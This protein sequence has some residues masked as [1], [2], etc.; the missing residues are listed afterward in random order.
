MLPHCYPFLLVDRLPVDRDA[1]SGSGLP[2]RWTA[3]GALDRGAG[4]APS[5]LA[6]EMMAQAG[7]VLL[8][9]AADGRDGSQGGLLAGV[10]GVQ[11]HAPVQ[12]GD[13]LEAHA[14]LSGRFG[15]LVKAR[16]WI[17]REGVTVAEGELLLALG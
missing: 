12:A 1:G 11:I 9:S 14:A 15:R 7:L 8:A 3:N 6:V 16:A 17:L 10:E 2:L 5:M 13:R 4:A